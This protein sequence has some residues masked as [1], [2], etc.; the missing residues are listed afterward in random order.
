M[1]LYTYSCCVQPWG[2]YNEWRGTDLQDLDTAVPTN[3]ATHV[4]NEQRCGILCYRHLYD[5]Q[6]SSLC[7]NV[8]WLTL[9]DAVLQL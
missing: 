8:Q 3:D 7:S 1:L 4:Q 5:L 2:W 6:L 9:Q